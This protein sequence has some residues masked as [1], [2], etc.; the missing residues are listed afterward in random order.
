MVR[1]RQIKTRISYWLAMVGIQREE[2]L[3]LSIGYLLYLLLFFT[4]WL[5][6]MMFLASDILVNGAAPLLA[7]LG[8]A[9]PDFIPPV[10]T[11]LFIIW[12][13]YSIHKATLR[14]PLIFSKDDAA[15]LCQTPADRRFVTLV[16]LLG[17]WVQRALMVSVAS[18][19]AGFALYELAAGEEEPLIRI[20]PL[21]AAALKPLIIMIP[22]HLG[23]FALVWMVGV[24]RLRRGG[25]KIKVM[26]LIRILTLLT[27]LV[28]SAVLLGGIFSPVR[29]TPLKP[30]LAA[31]TLPL[32]TAYHGGNWG[33][34]LGVPMG[35]AFAALVGLWRISDAVNL[36]RAA[37]E[38][39]RIHTR[40]TAFMLGNFERIHQM[41]ER[42]RLGASQK[43][44]KIPLFSGSWSLSWKHTVQSRRAQFIPS[45]WSWVGI[46]LLTVTVMA[47]G[48]LVEDAAYLL[49]LIFYWAVAVGQKTSARLKDD[50]GNWW[51]LQ[52]LPFPASQ[53][54]LHGL[55]PP[56]MMTVIL[57]W[58]ALWASGRLGLFIPPLFVLS[59][60][61]VVTGIALSHA[62]D[63]LRRADPP[64]LLEGRAPEAGPV[65]LLLSLLWVAIPATVHAVI[66]SLNMFPLA[67]AFAVYLV[68]LPAIILLFRLL[69]R[70]FVQI[71]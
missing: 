15:L 25:K 42:E 22:L 13:A 24:Y 45:L 3:L 39:H 70:R 55:L 10:G 61:M 67:S 46:G 53:T 11:F 17:A 50:L 64:P 9:L 7:S 4:A 21:A 38:T 12:I 2:S 47:A 30:F 49:P 56:I 54:I 27:T 65:G 41:Q 59:A 44:S 29:F 6:G 33:W 36:S 5:A 51:L 52:S 43:P 32:E 57:T 69:E 28:L 63:M 66:T 1:S 71:G 62:L 48:A 14:S 68:G 31:L 34:G 8:I 23:L 58:T 18:S 26:R 35:L 16:W 20:G 37:Q 60:P 19:T 40:R